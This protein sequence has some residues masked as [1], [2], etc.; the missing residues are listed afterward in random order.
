[1]IWLNDGVRIYNIKN[2]DAIKVVTLKNGQ[3]GISIGNINFDTSTIEFS[4]RIIP[5]NSVYQ[6]TALRKI[7]SIFGQD[8][9]FIRK[10]GE[11]VWYNKK[12]IKLI[13]F[14]PKAGYIRMIIYLIGGVKV[15][16]KVFKSPSGVNA[17]MLST[18][19][20]EVKDGE[21]MSIES[22]H[23]GKSILKFSII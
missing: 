7:G 10:K 8:F 18:F 22:K 12:S 15:V 6:R 17:F 20:N 19:R 3:K 14:V 9:L 5:I 4:D 13:E 16:G 23:E 1:M 11:N 21:I 2:V